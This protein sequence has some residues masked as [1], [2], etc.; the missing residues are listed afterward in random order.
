MLAY[1]LLNKSVDGVLTSKTMCCSIKGI[2]RC[3]RTGQNEKTKTASRWMN[4]K[5]QLL[6]GTLAIYSVR[7]NTNTQGNRHTWTVLHGFMC[8]CV[9]AEVPTLWPQKREQ[10]I[11]DYDRTPILMHTRIVPGT[12]YRSKCLSS[13]LLLQN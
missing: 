5:Y 10:V 6:T 2:A 3:R 7:R 4:N 9:H 11:L 1:V 13:S 8:V 12:R